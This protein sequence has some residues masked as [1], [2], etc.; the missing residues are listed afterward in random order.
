M[1]VRTEGRDIPSMMTVCYIFDGDKVLLKKA[2]RGISEG[3]WVGLGGKMQEGESFYDALARE[4]RE[5]AGIEPVYPKYVG[6]KVCHEKDAEY[7]VNYFLATEFDGKVNC[8]SDEGE[9]KW[10]CKAEIPYRMMW[11]EERIILPLV[12]GSVG[13]LGDMMY[14][15]R[16]NGHI[17]TKSQS[18]FFCDETS[19]PLTIRSDGSG[20]VLVSGPEGHNLGFIDQRTGQ[21]VPI[22][23]YAR[24]VE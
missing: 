18:Y 21:A 2:A 6:R 7:E 9:V 14:S 12:E 20:G 16:L 13:F 19:E 24:Q 17:V 8:G 11:P 10:F 4:I 3:R 5:E 15:P 1:A 23:K 22:F